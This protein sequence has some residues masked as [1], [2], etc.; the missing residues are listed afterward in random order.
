[1]RGR[2]F[3]DHPEKRLYLGGVVLMV[4]FVTLALGWLFAVSVAVLLTAVFFVVAGARRAVGALR[5]RRKARAWLLF[6]LAGVPLSLLGLL[7][8]Y[9]VGAFSGALSV[10]KSCRVH[11]EYYDDAYRAQHAGE[12]DRWFPLHNKCNADFDLVPAWVNPALV[13]FAGLLAAGLVAAVTVA[14]THIRT[15]RTTTRTRRNT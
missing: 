10:R 6:V 3:L 2:D 8:S 1:M 9:C 14:V 11:Q 15:T 13:I 12:M 5:A 4:L 7:V